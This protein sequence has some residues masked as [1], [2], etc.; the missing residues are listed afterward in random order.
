MSCLRFARLFLFWF[1]LLFCLSHSSVQAQI[2]ADWVFYGGKVLTANTDD[3]ANFTVVQAVAIYDGKFVVVGTDQQALAVAGP[4]T[5]R[6][7][8][9]ARTV[10]PGLVHTHL[11]VHNQTPAHHLRDEIHPGMTDRG[12]RWTTKE[13][14]LAKLRSMA[15]GKEPGGWIVVPVEGEGD[16]DEGDDLAGAPTL[17]ELDQVFPDRPVSLVLADRFAI[18]NSRALN[19][20]LERYPNG[21]PEIVRGPDGKPTGLLRNAAGRTIGEFYPALTPRRV[22][23]LA[24]YYK[25]ELEEPAARGVTTLSTR[26]DQVSL[27]MYQ[28]L[29]KTDDL[30]VRIAYGDQSGTFHPL[31]DAI[32]FGAPQLAGVGHPWLWNAG[33]SPGPQDRG[34]PVGCTHKP[35]PENDSS[36]PQWRGHPF[37]PNGT[38]FMEEDPVSPILR[39]SILAAARHGFSLVGTH[40]TGDRTIDDYLEVLEE[41]DRLYGGIADRR[42]SIDHCYYLSE[43]QAQRAARLGVSP[44]CQPPAPLNDAERTAFGAYRALYGLEVAGDVVVPFQRMVRLGMKPSIHC[45]SHRGW[46][47]ACMQYAITRKDNKDGRVWGP[48]QR[49]NRRQALYGYTRW[50]AWHTHQENKIGS[51]EVGKWGD[52]VVIDKDFLEIDEDQIAQIN[53]LLTIA[54]GKVTY[55]EP[56]FASSVGLPSVGFRAPANWWNR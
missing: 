14:G 10:L 15:Q 35:Y 13:E 56:N 25:K 11:H 43:E 12:L 31:S 51:I 16:L 28:Y 42:F 1:G 26:M 8:L 33:I 6:V 45:E 48:Q 38:C 19:M 32:Y 22:A 5:R 39:G 20:M 37:G 55:S 40:Q 34:G 30:P 54:G 18:V 2:T 50:A 4:N 52:L 46:D 49:I 7:N 17:A 41:A 27:R 47:F 23:E 9:R 44:S 53:P 21:V 3:P 29:A 36:F 24:P